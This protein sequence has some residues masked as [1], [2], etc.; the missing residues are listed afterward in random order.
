MKTIFCFLIMACSAAFAGSVTLINDSQ[1]LLKA[2]VQAA[3]GSYLGTLTVK[4]GVTTE[5][6]ND[7]SFSPENEDPANSQT[8]YMVSWT[9]MD[10]TSFSS[11]SDVPEGGTV[12]ALGGEGP[13]VC[14][15]TKN[16]SPAAPTPPAPNLPQPESTLEY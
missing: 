6:T 12:N 13:R 16:S 11:T 3:N 9:C 7:Y 5:W 2:Y 15:S 4:P 10:E 8:P 14:R 1:Y